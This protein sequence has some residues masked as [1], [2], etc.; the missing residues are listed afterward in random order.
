MKV[1]QQF[2]VV[3]T[4]SSQFII[5]I[6]KKITNKDNGLFVPIFKAKL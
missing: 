1:L 6:T 2:G 5:M 4:M 3:A